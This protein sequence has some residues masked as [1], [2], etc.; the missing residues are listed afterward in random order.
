[1]V[2]VGTGDGQDKEKGTRE[3]WAYRHTVGVLTLLQY[4]T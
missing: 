4:I 1:M 3:R 2:G